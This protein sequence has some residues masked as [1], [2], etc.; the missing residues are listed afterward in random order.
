M[1]RD[2]ANLYVGWEVQDDTPWVNGADAPE[3]MY[4][5]GDTVDLQLGTDPAADKKRGE[6]VKG[7][8]QL[9][10]HQGIP[11]GQRRGAGSGQ[12]GGEGGCAGQAL[13]RIPSWTKAPSSGRPP[14]RPMAPAGLPSAVNSST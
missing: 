9:R 7:D 10:R 6:P 11:D 12:G 3:F 8:L 14:W 2:D 1:A 13:R 4:A 5:R